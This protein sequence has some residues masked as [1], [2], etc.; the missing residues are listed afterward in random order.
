M[1]VG[2]DDDVAG[3]D[4][5]LLGQQ[6][7]LDAHLPHV[8]KMRDALLPGKAAALGALLGRENVLVWDEV[9]HDQHDLLRRA[10]PVKAGLLHL[11]DGHRAGDIVGQHAVQLGIDQLAG[12]HPLQ[13]GGPGQY[14]LCHCHRHIQSS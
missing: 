14:L 3:G 11:P 9:V 4:Q 13:P 6:G 2:A 5:P 10:H 12:L 7:V 8:I 1:R